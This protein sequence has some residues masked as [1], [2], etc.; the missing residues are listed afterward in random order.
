M[1]AV[2]ELENSVALSDITGSDYQAVFLP[3]GH[4][5]CWD[6]TEDKAL[7]SLIAS[8]YE[9]GAVVSSVCHGPAALANVQLSDNSYLIEGKNVRARLQ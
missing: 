5:V 2:A 4:G 6:M 9:S 1:S 3:G 8:M 7:Q